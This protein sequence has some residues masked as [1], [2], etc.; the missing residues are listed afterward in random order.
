MNAD[1][2]PYQ[3][4]CSWWQSTRT[5]RTLVRLAVELATRLASAVRAVVGQLRTGRSSTPVYATVKVP[6]RAHTRMGATPVK[7][8]YTH[9]RTRVR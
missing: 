8:G 3:R 6:R 4:L 5:D 1:P 9:V 2:T 7:A